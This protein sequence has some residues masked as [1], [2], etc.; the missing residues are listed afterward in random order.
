MERLEKLLVPIVLAVALG[1]W[2]LSAAS[3]GTAMAVA[4]TIGVLLV[5][6]LVVGFAARVVVRRRRARKAAAEAARLEPEA[7]AP[8][9]PGGGGGQAIEGPPPRQGKATFHVLP[10][11]RRRGLEN[12]PRRDAK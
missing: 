1:A 8:A 9:D 5:L 10:R 4:R 12:G 6:L 7:T 11:G 2:W 3:P